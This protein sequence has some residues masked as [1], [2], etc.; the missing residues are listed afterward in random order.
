MKILIIGKNSRIT[1]FL[2]DYIDKS[3]QITVKNYI[4]VI[5]KNQIFFK[6]FNFI[7][8]CSSNK[9]YINSIYNI[10]LIINRINIFLI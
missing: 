1:Q 3:F 4:D 6:K 10:F 2:K 8:N 5:K 9:E 7:I